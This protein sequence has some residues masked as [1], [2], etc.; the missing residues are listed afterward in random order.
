MST[1]RRA[2]RRARALT[3]SNVLIFFGCAVPA[4]Q[5]VDCAWSYARAYQRGRQRAR[6]RVWTDAGE[7]GSRFWTDACMSEHLHGHNSNLA[8][9]NVSVVPAFGDVCTL[10]YG[11]RS[12]TVE[13]PPQAMAWPSPMAWPL[14]WP[15]PMAW[16][17]PLAWHMPR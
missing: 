12:V 1:Q 9:Y 3:L 7:Y 10:G 6:D 15:T 11:Q 17:T 2:P 8:H 16:P 13:E 14:V 4:L 5:I